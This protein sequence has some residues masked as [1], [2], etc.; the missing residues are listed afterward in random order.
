[1][2]ETE[3]TLYLVME[4]A[5]GG[6]MEIKLPVFWQLHDRKKRDARSKCVICKCTFEIKKQKQKTVVRTVSC[7]QNRI[8]SYRMPKKT[9]VLIDLL[10]WE[11]CSTCRLKETL[12]IK[13][14]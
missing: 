6:E 12:S 10:H 11:R 8:S 7:S 2:I 9:P 4:Y 14:N 5:S 3:R 1:M 13:C